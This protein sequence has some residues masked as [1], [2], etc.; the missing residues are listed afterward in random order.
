M[1][2]SWIGRTATENIS[3]MVRRSLRIDDHRCAPVDHDIDTTLPLEPR[4]RRAPR[5]SRDGSAIAGAVCRDDA[6]VIAVVGQDAD[7][8][9]SQRRIRLDAIDERGAARRH[10]EQALQ[11]DLLRLAFRDRPARRARRGAETRATRRSTSRRALGG[12]EAD[13]RNR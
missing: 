8:G 1:A 5:W 4:A 12:R 6:R 9:V 2:T 11:R 13:R 10:G 3:R 7:L